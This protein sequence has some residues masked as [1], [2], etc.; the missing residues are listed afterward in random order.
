MPPTNPRPWPDTMTNPFRQEFC[1]DA[2]LTYLNHAG[3]APIPIRAARRVGELAQRMSRQGSYR[4]F[5]MERF[6]HET[7]ERCASLLG[8][9]NAA[10]AFIPNTSTGLSSVAIGLDWRPGDE[11]ITTDQEFPSNL[12]VWLDVAR[13][14]G[15]VVHQ[16]AA[17]PQG[18]I[19]AAAI[20]ERL[21]PATR[22]ITVSSVQYGSGAAMDLATLAAATRLRETLLVVDAI[23]SLGVLPLPAAQW[24][25]DVVAADGHKWLLGPEGAGFLYL[26]DKAMAQVSPRLLG[27]HSVANA[28]DYTRLCTELRPGA[29]RFEPGSPNLLGVAAMGES[30][31][32]LLEVGS[33][34]IRQRLAHL[35]TLLIAA[36]QQRGCRIETPLADN[37]LP[38]AGILVFSHPDKSPQT[39]HQSLMQQG[40]VCAARG[41]G[42]RLSPHFYQDEEEVAR[43]MTVLDRL[44]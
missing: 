15:V 23:Q 18:E 13:R 4:Y 7:R 42:L 28:G 35:M 11:L 24:G 1:L 41:H 34:T 2:G 38:A 25:I 27:W 9:N 10:I 32:L 29:R 30:I 37:G 40:V 3:V 20:L 5:E 43:L 21:T 6:F 19:P 36:L 17:T 39:L 33:A 12:L 31:G 14:Y 8:V 22:L 16:V 26:S 44:L